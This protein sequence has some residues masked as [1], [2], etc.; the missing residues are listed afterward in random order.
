MKTIEEMASMAAGIW[1][2]Y[3][4]ACKKHPFFADA[5]CIR[6]DRWKREAR[7]CKWLIGEAVKCKEKVTAHT[8]L[9]A[10][11]YEIFDACCDGDI[12]QARYEVLDAIAVLLR[13]DDMLA[14]M[15]EDR[16]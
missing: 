7:E 13:M 2:H 16:G 5:I 3:E 6:T 15:Q 12:A 11:L 10:E 9:M 8:V 14:E 1:A 4:N